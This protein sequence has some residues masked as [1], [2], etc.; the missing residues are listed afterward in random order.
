MRLAKNYFY[1]S[2]AEVAAKVI[3]FAAIAYLARVAGPVAYGYF[4]FAAAAVFCA[5][6]IVDQGLGPYGAREIAKGSMPTA[7]LVRQIVS[8]RVVLAAIAAGALVLFATAFE[9]PPLVTQL[10][11]IYAL[12]LMLMPLLLQW[13]FQ[14]HDRMGVVAVLQLIRQALFAV[15]ILALVREPEQIWIV[16]VAE[17]VGIAGA[18]IYG[19]IAYRRLYGSWLESRLHISWKVLRESAPIGASQIFWVVRMYGAILILGLVATP[20]DVGFFGAAM[21]IFVA[22]HAF[23]YLYFFNQLAS[24]VR[25]WHTQDASLDTLIAQ[26]L[27]RVAGV[28]LF[29][30]PVWILTSPLVI[31]IAYGPAFAPAAMA[32]AWLAVVF[33][34]AWLDGHYRFTLIAAGYQHIEMHSQLFG[35]LVAIVLIPVLYGLG[36]LGGVG[37]ALVIGELVVWLIAWWYS[38][39]ELYLRGH[40]ALLGRMGIAALFAVFLIWVTTEMPLLARIILIEL[41]LVLL[42]LVID[43]QLRM[44]VF[45][46]VSKANTR[47]RTRLGRLVRLRLT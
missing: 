47:L 31:R 26:S 28:C 41:S 9:H 27:R 44:F 35:S 22:L 36:G 8:L 24:I 2:A 30:V 32:L 17:G 45:T 7:E 13:V 5:G 37:A 33:A 1:L 16:A 3:T 19:L 18:V 23:V 25:A 11:L 34:F 42:M 4:E 46:L 6:L 12:D 29:I 21:R 15:V 14:G 39:K 40:A 10:L 43:S 38:R 20:S